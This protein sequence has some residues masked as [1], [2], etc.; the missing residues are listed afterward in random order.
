M[1]NLIKIFAIE[2]IEYLCSVEIL[3]ILIVIAVVIVKQ[4]KGY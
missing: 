3:E 1:W 4:T 2:R